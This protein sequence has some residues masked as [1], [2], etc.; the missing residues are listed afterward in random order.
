MLIHY[1]AVFSLSKTAIAVLTEK[2]DNTYTCV[3][4]NTSHRVMQ[5]FYKN[6]MTVIMKNSI[7]IINSGAHILRC[8]MWLMR[9]PQK[10]SLTI[11]CENSIMNICAAALMH[12]TAICG[13]YNTVYAELLQ[14]N[15]HNIPC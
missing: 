11:K 9:I 3:H 4:A 15:L 12:Y 13:F 14:H 5:K 2:Q 6:S 1:T 8:I 7:M 10:N